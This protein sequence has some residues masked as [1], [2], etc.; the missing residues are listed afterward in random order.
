MD[1]SR[2]SSSF[3]WDDKLSGVQM[4]MWMGNGNLTTEKGIFLIQDCG[5]NF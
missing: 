3:F 1:A 2:V 5:V 4:V